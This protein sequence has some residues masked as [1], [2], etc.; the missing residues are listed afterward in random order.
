MTKVKICGLRTLEDVAAAN[1]C[2]PDYI[3]FVF[4]EKSKRKIDRATAAQLKGKLSEE[5]QAVGVFVN[6]SIQDIL[7]LCNQNVIDVIQLHGEEDERFIQQLKERLPNPIIKA[8]PVGKTIFKQSEKADFLLFDTATVE[9]GGSGKTFDWK[10]L[11]NEQEKPYFL[12]GGLTTEN[13]T[14][15]VSTLHPYCVDVSSGVE[16]AGKKDQEKMKRFVKLVQEA[17]K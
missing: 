11:S 5:I 17:T 9:R 12:A 13:V 8:I 3:G 2:L 15:A 14:Q 6:Q 4:A 7:D 10:L 16:T 1:V